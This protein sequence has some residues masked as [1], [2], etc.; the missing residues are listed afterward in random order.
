M[1]I[2]RCQQSDMHY[3]K[4]LKSIKNSPNELFYLGDIGL[5]NS[6]PCVAIIGSRKSSETG[7]KKAYDYGKIAAKNGFAVVNGLALGC[8]TQAIRG[9]LSE[10]GKC[11]A[12][13]PGG[14]D[15]IYPRSNNNLAQSILNNGGCL[16]S[17]YKPGTRPT[18][19]SFVHRDRLQS[20]ISY[21]VI[22]VETEVSGGTMHTVEFAQQ[23][24]RYLACYYTALGQLASGNRMIV[25]KEMGSPIDD[26]NSVADFL[27]KIKESD[28]KH[29]EQLTIFDLK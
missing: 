20:G 6:Q 5:F 2:C 17:E 1:E 9:A 19:Y 13:L 12:V 22:V 11:I 10:G 16:I 7:L 24:N 26:E 21:G 18:R 23:H 14:L 28:V 29:Y 27:A 4:R 25:D 8:D 15:E 3:P